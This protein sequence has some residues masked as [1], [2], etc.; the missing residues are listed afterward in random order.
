MKASKLTTL[1]FFTL[2]SS[3]KLCPYAFAP[4]NF[5]RPYDINFRMAE[6]EGT[7]VK[8]GANF[9]CGNTTKSRNGDEDKVDVL[10]LY[11]DT[12]SSLAMLMGSENKSVIKDLADKLLPAFAP[13]TDDGVRGR[14]KLEG[15]YE[16][17]DL[18]FWGKYKIPLGSMPGNF[19]IYLYIPIRYMD[20]KDVK[21]IDQ[22]KD[23]L[24]ADLDVHY[25]L[26]DDF[27]DVV[28]S[29]GGLDLGN[30]KKTGIGDIVVMLSWFNDFKQM[31][32]H[33]KNVRVSSRLGLSIPSAQEKDED[34]TFSLPLGNDKAW[35][36]PISLGLDVDFIHRIRVGGEFE[37]LV[38]F[39]QTDERRLKTDE[40]Q[41]DFL[42]LHKGMVTKSFGFTYK[43]N[44]FLQA[45]RFLGGLSA[46]VAYQF[47]KHDDDKLTAQSNDFSYQ[48]INSAQSLKEWGTQDFVFQLNYDFFKEC[49][50]SWFKPQLSF[51]YKLPITGKRVINAQ[52]F[53]GQLAV[54]F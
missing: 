49:K 14:F 24:S 31:K 17:A 7:K 9:E 42:L 37:M 12:E 26:T 6:W 13:A 52:T 25:Y 33:L 19:D 22:T 18:T 53:G 48:I 27:F 51:F 4:T 41:T 43:F 5:N 46:M 35:G 40:N 29:L 39:D 8:L 2:T 50:N 28:K 11:N 30:W 20:V 32:E 16:E 23:V 34:K 10:S 36:M 21:W 44:L 54:N 47:L 15:K 38:L 45:Q 1:F 3:F